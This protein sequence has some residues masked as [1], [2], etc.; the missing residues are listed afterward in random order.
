MGTVIFDGEPPFELVIQRL[1]V[2][3]VDG[4]AVILTFPIVLPGF[5]AQ[6]AD[7]RV[8]LM[9]EHAEQLLAQLQNI[10]Q[11]AQVRKGW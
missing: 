5:P 11:E 4:E 2:A 3:N 10:V 6:T 7:I 8:R 1:P 9:V